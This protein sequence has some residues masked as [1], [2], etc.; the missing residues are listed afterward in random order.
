MKSHR[1]LNGNKTLEKAW[2]IC[3]HVFFVNRERK[4]M[5]A[6]IINLGLDLEMAN[7]HWTKGVEFGNLEVM[8]DKFIS[9]WFHWMCILTAFHSDD[10][11]GNPT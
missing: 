6:L 5:S 11:C 9:L 8:S 4:V 3:C 7:D 2:N 10:L 1:I